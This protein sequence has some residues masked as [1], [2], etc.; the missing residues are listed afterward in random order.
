MGVV[1]V[2]RVSLKNNFNLN[3]LTNGHYV[4]SWKVS[5]WKGDWWKGDWW[6]LAN[7]L[8]P[9]KIGSWKDRF[10]E[11]LVRGKIGSW[12]DMIYGSF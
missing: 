1:T 4:F 12:K 7:P 6:K 5:S 9:G 10:V 3:K 2:S 8:V 11:R